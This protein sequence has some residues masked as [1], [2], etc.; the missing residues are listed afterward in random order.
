MR[1]LREVIVCYEHHR[2]FRAADPRSSSPLRPPHLL[3]QIVRVANEFD[4]LTRGRRHAQATSVLDAL[5]KMRAFRDRHYQ[6]DLFN[7]FEQLV[8]GIS[9]ERPSGSGDAPPSADGLDAMLAAFLDKPAP[10]AS[11][12]P[13]ARRARKKPKKGATLGVLKLKS[14]AVRRKS[15]RR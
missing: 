15:K 8:G 5:D 11:R 7:L 10:A 3:S 6:R 4:D 2:D 13:A 12:A 14:I 1:L 9:D